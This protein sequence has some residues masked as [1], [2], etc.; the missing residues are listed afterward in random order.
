MSCAT[1]ISRFFRCASA[2]VVSLVL[3]SGCLTAEDSLLDG[4]RKK[5]DELV[6]EGSNLADQAKDAAKQAVQGVEALLPKLEG[7]EGIQYTLGIAYGLKNGVTDDIELATDVAKFATAAF[8]SAIKMR[9]DDWEKASRDALEAARGNLTKLMEVT[10]KQA[11]EF[12]KYVMSLAKEIGQV[13]VEIDIEK[14]W[15]VA[16]STGS[17]LYTAVSSANPAQGLEN[18]FSGKWVENAKNIPPEMIDAVETAAFFIYLSYQ[19]V[20]NKWQSLS[21]FEKGVITGLIIY[22]VAPWQRAAGVAKSSVEKMRDA[23]KIKGKKGKNTT[24]SFENVANAVKRRADLGDALKFCI[25]FGT[26]VA[27]DGGEKPIESLAIGDLVRA[28]IDGIEQSCRVVGASRCIT[29]RIIDIHYSTGRGKDGVISLTPEHRIW[30]ENHAEWIASGSVVVGDRLALAADRFATVT[31]TVERR[32]EEGFEVADISVEEA[33]S[34]FIGE[35][36]VLVHNVDPP[37][38]NC[39]RMTNLFASCL[40]A[41]KGKFDLT[42]NPRKVFSPEEKAI[43]W[44]AFQEAFGKLRPPRS[45]KINSLTPQERVDFYKNISKNYWKGELIVPPTSTYNFGRN[46]N[47]AGT[48]WQHWFPDQFRNPGEGNYNN[49]LVTRLG[50]PEAHTG[51]PNGV[52]YV[53]EMRIKAAAPAGQ[54]PVAWFKAKTVGQ[55]ADFLEQV[56]KEEFSMKFPRD[57]IVGSDW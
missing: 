12:D 13:K 53:I 27:C 57:R 45:G 55:R 28:P 48:Q 7:N 41:R 54:D 21:S 44:D 16:S 4:W 24:I 1:A 47:L 38:R 46:P 30:C 18:I 39:E 56:Y 23:L 29:Y 17:S 42:P 22:A 33:H 52:D 2:F 9:K 50:T 6:K 34:F 43:V 11:V 32:S 10:E 35:D 37:L 25:L 40:D 26:M 19:E 49:G 5:A 3:F 15:L 20:G 51:K 31:Q 36:R 8:E 14:A